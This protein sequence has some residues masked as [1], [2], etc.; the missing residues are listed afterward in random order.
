MQLTPA[1]HSNQVN[2]QEK[3][4]GFLTNK[5]IAMWIGNAF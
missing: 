2:K 4:V 3:I 1:S 5:N